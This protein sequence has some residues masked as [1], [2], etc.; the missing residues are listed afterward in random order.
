MCVCVFVC[1]YERTW[2]I[3]INENDFVIFLNF[4]ISKVSFG[5]SAISARASRFTAL[6]LWLSLRVVVRAGPM[7]AI[8]STV[9]GDGRC[10][11]CWWRIEL[12]MCRSIVD[13]NAQ[14]LRIENWNVQIW[15]VTWCASFDMHMF[16][17]NMAPSTVVQYRPVWT[18]K[19]SNRKYT[20]VAASFNSA[21]TAA[22]AVTDYDEVRRRLDA[23]TGTR[24]HTHDLGE[25]QMNKLIWA[26]STREK[27]RAS[28]KSVRTGFLS[29]NLLLELN[30]KNRNHLNNLNFWYVFRWWF[31]S[32]WFY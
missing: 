30:Y 9:V 15:P 28:A 16:R 13:A 18:E 19:K 31:R 8:V 25:N 2:Q 21:A 17:F 3:T 12:Q 11:P 23:N 6:A 27:H 22:A 10:T 24:T 29:S 20:N 5:W 1:S 32:E 7:G 4:N 14:H 26:L